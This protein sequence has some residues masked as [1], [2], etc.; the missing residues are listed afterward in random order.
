ML[1]THRVC[2]KGIFRVDEFGTEVSCAS[3]A[4]H[5]ATSKPIYRTTIQSKNEFDLQS[6]QQRD[7]SVLHAVPHH[8]KG[9]RLLYFFV[10]SADL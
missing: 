5:V 4:I 8:A 1:Q 10:V 2:R 9:E 6:K 3:F 7:Y